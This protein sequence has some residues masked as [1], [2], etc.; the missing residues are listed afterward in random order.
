MTNRIFHLARLLED[1][2]IYFTVSRHRRESF[3]ITATLI[4]KRI[5]IDVFEDDHIEFSVFEGDE[6]VISD[7][8][9]LFDLIGRT[10]QENLR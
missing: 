3:M 5:E 1:A 7:E 8:A 9:E 6:E 2:K 10:G 4:G